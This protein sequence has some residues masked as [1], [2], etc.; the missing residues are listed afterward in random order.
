MNR[1]STPSI[2]RFDKHCRLWW[3]TEF[4][5]SN[6]SIVTYLFVNGKCF[7]HSKFL[8]KI[9]YFS[10]R[11]DVLL[12]GSLFLVKRFPG[13]L[14]ISWGSSNIL[15]WF[16]S[17]S[18][19]L[20][21]GLACCSGDTFLKVTFKRHLFR[22][23]VVPWV[24]ATMAFLWSVFSTD[25]IITLIFLKS[26]GTETI[27]MSRIFMLRVVLWASSTVQYAE[28]LLECQSH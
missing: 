19:R 18:L 28:P 2:L 16:Q 13:F 7:V 4:I 3:N 6:N 26:P 15:I 9:I 10:K 23:Q 24:V 17:N 22:S 27:N 25:V 8:C 21:R 12:R 1:N 5:G 14:A 20:R 11:L